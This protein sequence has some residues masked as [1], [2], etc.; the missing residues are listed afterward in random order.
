M[1][2]K[3]EMM[4]DFSV[5]EELFPTFVEEKKIDR[6]IL[7]MLSQP[8]YRL[9][10]AHMIEDG[11][12]HFGEP[13]EVAIPKDGGGKR[14]IY[15]LPD[16]DRCVISVISHVYTKLYSGWIHPSC[17]SYQR[18]LSVPKTL[19]KV[20]HQLGSDGYKVD[21][22]KYFDSVPI[23]KINEMLQR[24]DT[25]SP[26]DKLLKEFYNTNFIIRNGKTV[27]H[28]KSL[29]QGCAFSPL[30]ANLCLAEVDAE[31]SE[32][33]EVYLRYSDDILM[34]G[35]RADEALVVLKQRLGELGLEL[36]PKK[37]Q[38]LE[39]DKEFTFLGGKICKDWVRF[40]EKSW[41]KQK[42]V[43][44]RITKDK[45]R[46]S[47]TVQRN[48]IKRLK[49]YLFS[50]VNG[51]CMMEYYCF[52]CTDET[53]VKRLDEYCRNELK[54]VY[55]GKHNHA[56][57]EHKTSNELLREMGWINLVHLFRLYKANSVIFK[58]KLKAERETA[59]TPKHVEKVPLI[60]L[61]NSQI[62]L[63][64]GLV[65]QNGV[66][67]CVERK[68]RP[69][70]LQTIE[71]LWPKARLWDGWTPLNT[72]PSKNRVYSATELWEIERSIRTVELLIV[73][74]IAPFE[75]YYW[76]STKFPELVIFRDWMQA[77]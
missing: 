23:W 57:N 66:Y 69:D 12:Y 44:R 60:W 75:Q 32:M 48:C 2:T 70:V 30:L 71:S 31:L 52:L 64:A 41:E 68:N 59:V 10:L 28:Y 53:D 1:D 74:S 34:L 22:S 19:H 54:A 8:K 16:V 58:A 67:Y 5:W 18:G 14:L 25:G 3:L 40:S 33:C 47:R 7:Q 72:S 36:N 50:E 21:L 43:V 29:G 6:E 61:T 4:L 17:V 20:R 55:T 38:K 9:G 45:K 73:T 42:A 56:M 13:R 65:R 35:E 15:V 49:K 76:Q 27:E 39:K 24:M 37:I 62:N 26:V 63:A 11:V 51:H 77:A 46:G